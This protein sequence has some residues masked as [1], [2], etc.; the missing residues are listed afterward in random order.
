MVMFFRAALMAVVFF[1]SGCAIRPLPEDVAGVPTHII[2]QQ[3]RCEARKAI[4]DSAIGWLTADEN[5]NDGRV[6][7]TSRALGFQFANGRP[8]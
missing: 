4:V 3:I 8:T 7:P 2:V 6:D 5:L 1:L